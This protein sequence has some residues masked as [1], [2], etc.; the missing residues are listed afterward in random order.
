MRVYN[1]LYL[2]FLY[3]QES[4]RNKIQVY[5]C[6]SFFFFFFSVPVGLF[7]LDTKL[8][9]FLMGITAGKSAQGVAPGEEMPQ[10]GRQQS[11]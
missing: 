7:L 9:Y 8:S 10:W 1:F 6:S 11:E 5:I 4:V 2:D 3:F